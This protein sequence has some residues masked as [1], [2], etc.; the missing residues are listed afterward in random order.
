MRNS[1]I[2]AIAQK[3]GSRA[4]LFVEIVHVQVGGVLV[5]PTGTRASQARDA[6]NPIDAYQE[7]EKEPA[8]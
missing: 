7:K 3:D 4:I 2:L 5:P 8:M 1:V 6:E